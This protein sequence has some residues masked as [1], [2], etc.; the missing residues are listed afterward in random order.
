MGGKPLYSLFHDMAS[1]LD[2]LAARQAMPQTASAPPLEK[3]AWFPGIGVM[4]A[5]TREEDGK[6]L[7]VAAKGGNN[8]ESHNHNDVGNVIVYKDGAPLLID[9]GSMTYTRQ[10]FSAARYGV[11][12]MQSA[13]HNLP[14]INGFTQRDGESFKAKGVSLSTDGGRTLFSMDISEAYPKEAGV[15]EWARS[16]ALNGESVQITEA[17]ALEAPCEVILR[18]MLALRPEI[19][20]DAAFQVGNGFVRLRGAAF[21]LCAEEIQIDDSKLRASWGNSLWRVSAAFGAG[22][23]GEIVTVLE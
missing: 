9:T 2:E 3:N 21:R 16:V 14:E 12:T 19:L 10:T 8:A 7:A 22:A 5:R 13:Y 11:W 23:K 1:C 15:L 4:A 17:F 20:S 18:F 6:G